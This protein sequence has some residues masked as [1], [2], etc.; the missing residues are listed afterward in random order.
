MF[1]RYRISRRA[2]YSV[3]SSLAFAIFNRKPPPLRR[4]L[5]AG[6]ARLVEFQA[7]SDDGS[8]KSRSGSEVSSGKVAGRGAGVGSGR[9][10]GEI[11]QGTAGA[12]GS[13]YDR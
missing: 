7:L 2:G 3:L 8:W 4:R 13:G 11:D 6:Q 9:D 10:G 1:R 5:D 12:Y